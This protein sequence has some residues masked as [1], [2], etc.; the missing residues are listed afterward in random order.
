MSLAY[1]HTHVPLDTML[2]TELVVEVI[3]D[4]ATGPTLRIQTPDMHL[5]VTLQGTDRARALSLFKQRL[6]DCAQTIPDPVST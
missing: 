5:F 4:A 2:D 6:D 3:D 1:L